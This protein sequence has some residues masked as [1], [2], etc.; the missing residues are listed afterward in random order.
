MRR[1][2]VLP[3]TRMWEYQPDTGESTFFS[4]GA[5]LGPP[6]G[7][8][9]ATRRPTDRNWLS[10]VQAIRPLLRVKVGGELT[11]PPRSIRGTRS[12]MASS[13]SLSRAARPPKFGW[14]DLP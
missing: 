13:S 12:E 7:S 9:R 14:N 11:A 6:H 3:R 10:G 2:G 5:G 4:A 1:Q 8:V